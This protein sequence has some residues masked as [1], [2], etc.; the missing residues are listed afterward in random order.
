MAAVSRKNSGGFTLLEL[1][2]VLFIFAILF[3]AAIPRMN[4]AIDSIGTQNFLSDLFSFSRYARAKSVSSSFQYR[5]K[6]DLS[7]KRM[8]LETKTSERWQVERMRRIPKKLR[9]EPV[10]GE[11]SILFYPDGSCSDFSARAGSGVS[12]YRITTDPS[13]GVVNVTQDP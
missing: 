13:C 1:V 11:E 4:S 9:I 3:S 5:I 6:L 12:R 2:F 7:E 10:N 8:L